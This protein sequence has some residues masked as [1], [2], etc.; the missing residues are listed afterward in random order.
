MTYIVR[1]LSLIAAIAAVAAAVETSQVWNNNLGCSLQ[2]S[3]SAAYSQ[4]RFRGF[5]LILLT[6]YVYW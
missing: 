3:S 6:T 2:E 1:V 4:L 5:S